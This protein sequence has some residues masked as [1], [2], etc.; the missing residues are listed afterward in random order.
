MQRVTFINARGE[1]IELYQ[2]P[3]FLNEIKGLGDV[4]SE[5]YTQ[6]A[7]EQDGT[8]PVYTTLEERY[9]P[10]EVVILEN[11]L[12]NRQTL[13]RVFN[14]ILGP[15][16]LIYDN[17]MVQWEINAQSEHVPTFPDER[18]RKVQ[19]AYIDLVCHDPYW[20][21][22]VPIKNEIA[23]WESKFSFELE[24][25]EEGIEMGSR[26]ASTIVNV[27]NTGHTDTGMIIK[28]EATQTVDNP[29][30]INMDTGEMIKIIRTMTAGE[31]ITIN[32]NARQKRITS[33]LN[34]IT[35]NIFNSIEHGSKFIQLLVGDNLLRYGADENQDFLEVSIYHDNK[36]VGV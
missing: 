30:L 17:G 7:P 8:T 13:S 33:E 26:S 4:D 6:K 15:G 11:L 1:S 21:D 25:P 36:Y 20:R 10:I 22:G 27:E 16:R 5:I 23:L 18:P 31:V 24:I 12:P 28:F 29:Y 34:G 9:I 3:F 2:S 19:R 14:P 32:T 35:T